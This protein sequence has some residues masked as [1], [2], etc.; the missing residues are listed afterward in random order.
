MYTVPEEE[1]EGLAE[2]A[3]AFTGCSFLFG[4]LLTLFM[5]FVFWRILSRAGYSGWLTLVN[6]IP[7]G[8]LGLLLLLAFGNWPALRGR[9]GPGEQ[10]GYGPP[11]Y[12][13]PSA[14]DAPGVPREH[15][16]PVPPAPH[17]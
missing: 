3:A 13:P 14:P 2:A 4:L 1:F 17:V 8:T 11:A 10:V 16:P 9:G 7:F 15:N 5:L 6:L 12:Q